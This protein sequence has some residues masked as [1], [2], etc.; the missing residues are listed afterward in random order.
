M[1]RKLSRAESL[2]RAFDR[3]DKMEPSFA[4]DISLG[5]ADFVLDYLNST[6]S[7][8]GQLARKASVRASVIRGAC[9]GSLDVSVMQWGAILRAMGVRVKIVDAKTNKEPF[10]G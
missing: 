7:T 8:V 5:L 4:A 6:D 3:L 2:Q 10:D 1:T 9:G